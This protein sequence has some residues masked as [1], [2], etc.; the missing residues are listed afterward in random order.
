ME[1]KKLIIIL[2]VTILVI[3]VGILSF[4]YAWYAFG[5]AST[6]FKDVK[7]A[8]PDIG[9]VFSQTPHVNTTT[10]IPISASDVETKADKNS[11][12]IDTT[13]DKL[14]GL[15]IA[16]EISLVDIKI[17]NELKTSDF[18]YELLEKV[19]N[20]SKKIKEGTGEDFTGDKL[21]L[22]PMSSIE[23]GKTYSYEL[24]VWLQDSGKSQNE[25]MEKSFSAKLQVSSAIKK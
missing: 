10:G 6:T 4:S 17:A 7:T 19:D 25:L 24:R 22:K 11:F 23:Q 14:K 2:S 8:D 18:K 20:E 1:F 21:V 9:I 5:D 13:N 3:V 15:Q 16:I 12:S